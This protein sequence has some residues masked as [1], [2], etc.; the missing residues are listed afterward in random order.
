[1]QR[2]FTLLAFSLRMPLKIAKKNRAGSIWNTEDTR[3]APLLLL[4]VKMLREAARLQ[5][6]SF[7]HPERMTAALIL[8]ADHQQPRHYTPYAAI[9]QV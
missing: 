3:S 4:P 8:T 1:M 7:L 9:T 2:G 5:S 6:S